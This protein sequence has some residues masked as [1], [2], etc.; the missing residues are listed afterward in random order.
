MR[1][2]ILGVTVLR[3][4]APE[5]Q[6]L[7]EFNGHMDAIDAA[8]KGKTRLVSCSGFNAR[9]ELEGELRRSI[10]AKVRD[11]RKAH[12]L[13]LEKPARPGTGGSCRYLPSLIIIQNYGWGIW[14]DKE[15]EV[16]ESY[17]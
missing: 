17:E 3:L 11:F 15:S 10:A 6:E 1:E 12:A 14:G 16:I 5:G 2:V 13:A 4:Q 9:K 8:T 7:S